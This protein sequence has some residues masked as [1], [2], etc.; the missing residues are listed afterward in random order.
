[1]MAKELPMFELQNQM[2]A[3]LAVLKFKAKWL[4]KS[5]I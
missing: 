2:A 5:K 1:M 4:P 3:N